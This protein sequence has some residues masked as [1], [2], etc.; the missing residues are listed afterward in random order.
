MSFYLFT[1]F[2]MAPPRG[3]E[4]DY[5]GEAPENDLVESPLLNDLPA[6]HSQASPIFNVFT[7]SFS[8]AFLTSPTFLFK[9]F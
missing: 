2:R 4:S 7:D 3:A 5:Y 1:L 6:R 8:R 9:Y